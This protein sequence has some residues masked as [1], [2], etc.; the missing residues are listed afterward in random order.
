MIIKHHKQSIYQV[1]S[2]S[3]QMSILNN[4]VTKQLSNLCNSPTKLKTSLILPLL[5]YWSGGMRGAVGIRPPSPARKQPCGEG[6]SGRWSA[7][8]FS[9]NPPPINE[10][11]I[12]LPTGT[13][14]L[15]PEVLFRALAGF[16]GFVCGSSGQ[17]NRARWLVRGRS[18]CYNLV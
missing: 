12:P 16:L 3:K 11:D 2:T 15:P 5:G 13:A 18:P 4:L 10:V 8:R 9:L 6:S 17:R 7:G 1:Y 14:P